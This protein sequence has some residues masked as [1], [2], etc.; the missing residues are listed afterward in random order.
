MQAEVRHQQLVSD[1]DQMV[2][3]VAK[4]T[5]KVVLLSKHFLFEHYSLQMSYYYTDGRFTVSMPSDGM[6]VVYMLH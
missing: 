1:T 6:K 5:T 2:V 3:G 4:S